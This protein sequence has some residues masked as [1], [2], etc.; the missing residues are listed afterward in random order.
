MQWR[1]LDGSPPLILAHRGASG[2]RPEHTLEGYQ[3]ALEQ[4]ADVIEPDLVP[5]AD[6]V[7][8][9]RHDPGMARS[10][11]I[12]TR[13]AFQSRQQNGDW[14][15]DSLS[16]QEID[17]LRAIQPFPGRATE[18]DGRFAVPRWQ[19]VLD[20]AA[21]AALDRGGNIILYPELKSPADF[22]AHGVDPVRSFI[23]SVSSLP[24]GV[25]VWVQ[26]FEVEPLRRVHDETGLACCLGI[27]IKDDWFA[28]IREHGAWLGSLGVNKK[29]LQ[30]SSGG[31]HVRLVDAAHSA[32]LRVEGWTYR[33]DRL[34]AGFDNA[35][36]ELRDA[37][38]SGID[39][40]FCD[41]PATGLAVRR[42]IA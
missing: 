41:F 33:D 30:A 38:V 11:D 32:G 17:T 21:A 4:G 15:S 39:G 16:A 40:L 13:A 24:A 26:C 37:L 27:D 14:R 36:D 10:T 35:E 29:L 34:G 2:L 19:A 12:T 3:L 20:W 31:D 9:A 42:Q 6:G 22:I 5:S 28:A 8:Y 25:E 18:F 23:E 1:T 7:L